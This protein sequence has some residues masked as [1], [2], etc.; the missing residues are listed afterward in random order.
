M[1]VFGFILRSPHVK[2]W[3]I[4]RV[5]KTAKGPDAATRD[6]SPTW[7]WGE[8]GRSKEIRIVSLNGYSLTVF[9]S[10]AIV[11][12]LIANGFAPGCWTPATIMGED[13]IFN[14]P[15]TTKLEKG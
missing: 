2:T 10:L 4:E 11:E 1:N 5:E 7:L 14:L 9:S 8:A 15:G 6:A 13:F 12:R 3:L